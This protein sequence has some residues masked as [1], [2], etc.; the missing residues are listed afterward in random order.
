[1]PTK[2]CRSR[3]ARRTEKSHGPA[4]SWVYSISRSSSLRCLA[5][6]KR[7]Y[8]SRAR[9]ELSDRANSIATRRPE[10]SSFVWHLS[11]RRTATGVDLSRRQSGFRHGSYL[12]V[13]HGPHLGEKRGSRNSCIVCS[14]TVIHGWRRS[15]PPFAR[16]PLPR[17]LQP[18]KVPARA[19]RGR[20]IRSRWR[21]NQNRCRWDR[22]LSAADPTGLS[23]GVETFSAFSAAPRRLVELQVQWKRFLSASTSRL[24][25]RSCQ[26][27]D[28]TTSHRA[29]SVN[30]S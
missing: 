16:P 21:P 9:G 26:R 3:P 25:S 2:A 27:H 30:L 10:H 29:R 28:R 24:L 20:S 12:F 4:L 23:S 5:G 22:E 6:S 15:R 14:A 18:Q 11:C 17:D 7:L 1:M 8:L 13:T 19:R